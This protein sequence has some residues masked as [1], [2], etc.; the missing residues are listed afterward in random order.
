MTNFVQSLG[1]CA[2]IAQQ[3]PEVMSAPVTP[4]HSGANFHGSSHTMHVSRMEQRHHEQRTGL[5][6]TVHEGLVMPG[7]IGQRELGMIVFQAM[8]LVRANITKIASSKL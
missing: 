2:P 8:P 5:V 4:G 1:S 7:D 6:A 3:L